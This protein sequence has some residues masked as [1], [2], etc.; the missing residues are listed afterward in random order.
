M[1]RFSELS[2]LFDARGWAPLVCPPAQG[3][4]RLPLTHIRWS[5][6]PSAVYLSARAVVFEL[7]RRVISEHPYPQGPLNGLSV[8]AAQYRRTGAAAGQDDREALGG[9]LL[10][11]RQADALGAAGDEYGLEICCHGGGP[12]CESVVLDSCSSSFWLLTGKRWSTG[13]LFF[14]HRSNQA[15]ACAQEDV[16]LVDSWRA[17]SVL[18]ACLARVRTGVRSVPDG[19]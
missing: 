16:L 11:G 1:G 15:G 9:H 5:L 19:R 2:V 17:V 8:P 12:Q 10:R 18:E 4:A 7:D 13:L 14:P 3:G 6:S